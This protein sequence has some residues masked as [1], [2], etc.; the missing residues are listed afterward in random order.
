L[1]RLCFF[2]FSSKVF[3]EQATEKNENIA[4]KAQELLRKERFLT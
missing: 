3:G 2:F 1:R 4:E